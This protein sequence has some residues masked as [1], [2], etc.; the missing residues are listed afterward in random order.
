MRARAAACAGRDRSRC[1]ARASPPNR[2]CHVGD[3]F[4]GGLCCPSACALVV[5]APYLESGP[6]GRA[7]ESAHA[8]GAA[9]GPPRARDQ[10]VPVPSATLL[11]L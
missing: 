5:P 2:D 1:N 4:G 6:G 8:V 3:E 9:F 11:D 7:S 10:S